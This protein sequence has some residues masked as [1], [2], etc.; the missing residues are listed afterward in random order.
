MR[1]QFVF[2]AI[3]AKKHGDLSAQVGMF[4]SILP[5]LC[6]FDGNNLKYYSEQQLGRTEADI[7][8][9]LKKVL[10]GDATPKT[11]GDEKEGGGAKK[12]SPPAAKSKGKLYDADA[13]AKDGSET[14][15]RLDKHDKILNDMLKSQ[16]SI[17]EAILQIRDEII[18]LRTDIEPMS[19]GKFYRKPVD[20]MSKS[21]GPKRKSRS[22]PHTGKLE[23]AKPKAT[24]KK[25]ASLNE[26]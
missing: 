26:L 25:H 2:G 20:V 17:Q 14:Q 7:T 8:G 23:R 13:G 18:D 1:G 6:V 16:R 9:F 22:D 21:S 4:P 24:A 5:Q 10:A 15:S 12:A 11:P 19:K 3:D